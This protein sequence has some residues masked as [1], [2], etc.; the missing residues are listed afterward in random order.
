MT[1]GMLSVD[2][3]K[4]AGQKE[5]CLSNN[6]HR[7]VHLASQWRDPSHLAL[8]ARCTSQVELLGVS[9]G[10]SIAKGSLDY[11]QGSGTVDAT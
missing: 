8:C 7:R 3:I 9:S 6:A 5:V 11:A 2:L 4:A 1:L 10:A